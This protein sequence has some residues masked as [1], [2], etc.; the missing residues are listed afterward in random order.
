MRLVYA[1][2]DQVV[3]GTRGG[4][5]HVSAVA[6]Q[7]AALGHEVHVATGR[8]DGPTR[9]PA[10]HWHDI[11]A[12][13]ERPHLRLLRMGAIKELVA[14]VRP[15]AVIERY[16][17]FGGEGLIAA[18]SAGALAVLEV[19]APVVDYAGSPKQRLD[20]ALL[21]EPM[22]R[23]RDWQCR[24]ADLIVTPMREILPAF[25]D[26]SRVLEAEWGADTRAFRPD[27]PGEAP[28]T[29]RDEEIVVIFAGAF[30]AWHGAVHLVD[31][32]AQLESRGL[33]F[34]AIFVGDGPEGPRVAE[35]IAAH[36]L[37]R[38]ALTGAIPHTAMPAALAAADIGAAPFDV[39]AHA[40]LRDA[41]Y[42]SPLKVFEYMASGLPV[43]C[44]DLPRLRHLV[45]DE[46]GLLYDA[47]NPAAL[48]QAIERLADPVSRA[49]LARSARDRALRL[50]SWEAHC[51]LLSDAISA[52]LR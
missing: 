26:R 18:R 7:L 20:R 23:W 45:G 29:R 40:P 1:A 31:A 17:N 41:F 49:T 3:P 33:P 50:Y 8:G 9:D 27:A 19:N 13:F 16:H 25:V 42:W 32:M 47:T 52:R 28:F 14:R 30:R 6:S 44:P 4:S 15:D 39:A 10:V 11:A 2:I 48:A 24:R 5:T 21:V 35:R 22:R 12:P 38:V 37:R 34:R 43:V 51:R 36:G 46:G